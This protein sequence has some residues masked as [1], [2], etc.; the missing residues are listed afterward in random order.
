MKNFEVHVG[1]GY[2]PFE[3]SGENFIDAIE[4]NF[5]HIAKVHRIGN[6]AGYKLTEVVAEYKKGI[7]GG[8]GGVV[9]YISAKGQDLAHKPASPNAQTTEVWIFAKPEDLPERYVFELK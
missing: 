2:S 1:G 3:I 5:D 7:L 9:L 4:K 8:K 6:A